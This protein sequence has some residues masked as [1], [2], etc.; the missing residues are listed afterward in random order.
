MFKGY[1]ELV[2]DVMNQ[3]F[4][5]DGSPAKHVREIAQPALKRFGFGNLFKDVR[6]ALKAL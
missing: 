2:R 5:I 3:M 4:V 6:G 1:P